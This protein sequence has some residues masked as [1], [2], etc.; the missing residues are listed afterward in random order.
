M[1]GIAGAVKMEKDLAWYA[2]T[3]AFRS[4]N[5][6]EDLLQLLKEYCDAAEY[7]EYG[8]AIA[9]AIHVVIDRAGDRRASGAR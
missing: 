4:T 5:P 7:E 3:M 2:I 9:R 8:K 6:L 1:H